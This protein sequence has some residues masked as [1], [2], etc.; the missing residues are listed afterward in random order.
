MSENKVK[1]H[2]YPEEK[3]KKSDLYLITVKNINIKP[4]VCQDVFNDYTKVFRFERYSMIEK[5]IAWAELPEPYNE[6][7]SI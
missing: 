6:D 7:K 5:I 1:W 2:P 4:F 3:P